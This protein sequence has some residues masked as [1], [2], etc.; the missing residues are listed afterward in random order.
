M[1]GREGLVRV[2]RLLVD[3]V[4]DLDT[5]DLLEPAKSVSPKG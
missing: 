5:L 4:D 2:S 1:K 3:L